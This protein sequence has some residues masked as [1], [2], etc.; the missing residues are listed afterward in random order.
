MS[1]SRKSSTFFT[2]DDFKASFAL[3]C[4]VCGIGTLG[5]PANFARAGPYLGVVAL[6]F[7]ASANVY[8]S[9][10]LSKAM[11]LAPRSVK[12]YGDLG[13]WV[14]G[15][16]GRYLVTI[17]QVL[18]CLLVPCAFLVLGSLLFQVLFPS[19][20][21]QT[22]W[23]VFMAVAVFPVALVPTMK[24]GA[25]VMFA[26]C[27]GTII[28][29]I[30]GIAIIMHGMSGH[31]APPSPDFSLHQV[32]TAFGNLSL[33]YGAAVIIPDLQ[34]EHSEPHRMPKVVFVTL[35]VVTCFFL[36]L[37]A[38]GYSAAGCQI[39]GNLLFSIAGSGSTGE[40]SLGFIAD[41]GAVIMAYIF[42]QMHLAIAFSTIIHPAFFMFERLVLGMHKKQHMEIF[43]PELDIES[44][45]KQSY[46]SQSTPSLRSGEQTP[47]GGN[48]KNVQRQLEAIEHDDSEL[49]E[50]KGTRNVLRYVLL[51]SGVIACLVVLAVVLRDHFLDLSD[52]IGAS[53][54]TLSCLILPLVFY[55]KLCWNKIPLYERA[56]ALAII[57]L[58]S[59][60]GLYVMYYTGK[61]LFGAT[62][63]VTADTPV[64]GFCP[65]EHQFK[66]YYVKNAATTS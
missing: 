18:V 5:M 12:N 22:Y 3:F 16:P 26:G 54:V 30:V 17:S 13:E 32:V 49:A 45:E 31:P 24:E 4:C 44:L 39:S 63:A 65:V 27:M 38:L 61:S 1:S 25:G 7:M 37:A 14:M 29:D 8:A 58:C 51:R 57:L 60:C 11:L 15:K 53:A 56:I 19:A 20:F 59:V 50:Y 28:A 10:T 48:E 43:E 47:E 64:F 52:F 23:I 55:M 33:A 35:S 34:R 21:S 66:P 46:V 2:A 40:T 9:V 42:M 41:R 6:V 62:A 36:T